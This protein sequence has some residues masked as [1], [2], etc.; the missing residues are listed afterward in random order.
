[1]RYLFIAVFLLLSGCPLDDDDSHCKDATS[2]NES[3]GFSK[4][5]FGA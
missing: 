2:C 3:G 1:M 4:R 5:I